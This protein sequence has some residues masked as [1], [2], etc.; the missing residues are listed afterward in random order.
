M[1]V[2][3]SARTHYASTFRLESLDSRK[4]FENVIRVVRQWVV[5]KE[6][7]VEGLLGKWFYNDGTWR[8]H[9]KPNT[10]ISTKSIPDTLDGAIPE[11]WTFFYQHSDGDKLIQ[12]R[13]FWY[14]EIGVRI[15]DSKVLGIAIRVSHALNKEYVGIE[16]QAPSPS[17]PRVV[18][19]WFSIP[20]VVVK[21]GDLELSCIPVEIKLG[22]ADLLTDAIHQ[23]GRYCPVVFIN[24]SID[25]EFFPVCPVDLQKKLAGKAQVFF[26]ESDPELGEELRHLISSKYSCRYRSLR[27]YLPGVDE[28]DPKD[29]LRHRFF[30]F[31]DLGVGTAPQILEAVVAS[32]T[33]SF[34]VRDPLSILTHSEVDVEIA[35]RH[36]TALRKQGVPTR[37][38]I[39]MLEEEVQRLETKNKEYIEL[40][41]AADE[42]IQSINSQSDVLEARI[43]SLSSFTFK[44]DSGQDKLRTSYL[45]L[46]EENWDEARPIDCLNALLF[47]YP[48][49]VEILNS[50]FGSAED[51]KE[52]KYIELLWEL[53]QKLVKDYFDQIQCAGS[54]DQVGNKVFGQSHFAAK[55]SETVERSPR[56]IAKRTFYANGVE[57]VM[58]RHLKI[59]V[60]DSAAETIRVHFD[61]DA[62]RKLLV[63]G[64]CGPHL[65]LA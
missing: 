61:W 22:K 55:E 42:Q 16:P 35:R 40:L 34:I 19:D 9:V 21:S 44:G 18:S 24:G 33:R 50:A 27:V 29:Y 52:F 51:S 23:T 46:L 56:L 26:A 12:N 36:L 43:Q 38:Y 49:R 7:K 20:G 65:P 54:G 47:L 2:P 41:N 57:H 6:G 60:K 17:A 1:S 45:K 10:Y 62:K 25:D 39:D 13:R 53:L 30:S 15:L 37:Q 5:K 64:H 58:W 32:I 3:Q 8:N 59:G 11:G 48:A 4:T 63:I 31:D 14:T 28:T